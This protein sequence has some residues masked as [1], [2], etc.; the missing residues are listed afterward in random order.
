MQDGVPQLKRR[1][2]VPA[3]VYE[4]GELEHPAIPGLMLALEHRLYGAALEY[5]ETEGP[6]AGE[7]KMETPDQ[8]R[9]RVVWRHTVAVT[10]TRTAGSF[11]KM[12]ISLFPDKPPSS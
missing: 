1:D 7:I 5:Y 9:F 11:T 4:A 2:S 12:D 8:K 3:H 10:P 6:N